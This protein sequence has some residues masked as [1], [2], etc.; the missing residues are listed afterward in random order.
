MLAGFLG[1]GWLSVGLVL[2]HYIFVFDPNKDPFLADGQEGGD[3]D[4]PNEW[5][6]NPID[7]LVKDVIGKGLRCI[8]INTVWG[9]ALEM[10]S[11]IFVFSGIA[12]VLNMESSI[13]NLGN[14]R[15]SVRDRY[16]NSH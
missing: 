16:W 5:K 7:F 11:Q 3:C 8:K 2:L 1:P 13:V 15:R 9:N 10:A 12:I 6:A 4:D 14:V